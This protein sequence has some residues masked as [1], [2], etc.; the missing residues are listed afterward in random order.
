MVQ[1]EWAL[2]L[3]RFAETVEVASF[4]NSSQTLQLKV[5]C[6][7]SFSPLKTLNKWSRNA[8]QS[9]SADRTAPSPLPNSP[10]L[11]SL[12]HLPSPPQPHPLNLAPSNP[13]QPVTKSL[14]NARGSVK[15]ERWNRPITKP[16]IYPYIYNS[17]PT[18]G[19][20]VDRP[21]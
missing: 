21:R 10:P 9:S 15:P 20:S 8:F 18:E 7:S 12:P 5:T 6:P 19:E 11:P 4:T 3:F 2:G 13:T 14:P 17:I 16:G 1:T